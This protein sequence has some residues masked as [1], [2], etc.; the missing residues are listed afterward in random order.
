MTSLFVGLQKLH[1]RNI[2]DVCVDCAIECNDKIVRQS[3][4]T[5]SGRSS[6]APPPR[7]RGNATDHV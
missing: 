5:R 3:Y 7:V 6:S 2:L 4:F 1:N